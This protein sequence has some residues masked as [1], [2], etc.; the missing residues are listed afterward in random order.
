M[1]ALAAALVLLLT[2]SLDSRQEVGKPV[3]LEAD[4]K[5]IEADL[6]HA[7]PFVHDMDGD[8]KRDLLVGQFGD[9][10]LK[11]YRNIGTN[12]AP[13]FAASTWFEAGG[14]VAHVATG[15]CIGFTPQMADLDGDGRDDLVTGSF[16]PGNLFLY[17]ALANGGFAAGEMLKAADGRNLNGGGPEYNV[18][19]TDTGVLVSVPFLVDHDGDGDFDL[20]IGN[21]EGRV[22]FIPNEGTAKKPSFNAAKRRLILAGGKPIELPDGAPGP[23]AT[24]WDGDGRTDLVVGAADGSVW[25]YRNAGKPG[26]PEYEDGVAILPKSRAGLERPVEPGA[27]PEGPGARAKI[28]VTDWNGDGRMDLLVGDLWSEKAGPDALTREENARIE[29]L[30][31]RRG[32]LTRESS[33]LQAE[34]GEEAEKDSRFQRIQRI[35][36]KVDQELAALEPMPV[37]HGSVWLF[38]REPK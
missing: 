36:S 30:K 13:R 35:L 17:R 38:L 26:A 20:L 15:C 29:E 12:S 10:R 3:R 28:C 24:D 19:E 25:W 8:G 37:L 27:V 4:A 1:H 9:G 23:V 11:I 34:L 6:G 14:K 16:M 33:E 7:A 2:G 21:L 18:S 22:V 5:P 31:K 32:E